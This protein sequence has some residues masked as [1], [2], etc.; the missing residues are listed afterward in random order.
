MPKYYTDEYDSC[1]ID[2]ETLSITPWSCAVLDVGAVL[3]K[4]SEM[5]HKFKDLC[6][7]GFH[8][9]FDVAHQVTDNHRCIDPDT[10]AWWEKQ[11]DGAKQILLPSASD[12]QLIEFTKAFEDWLNSNSIDLYKMRLYARGSSFDI[13]ILRSIYHIVYGDSYD[14]MLPFRYWRERDIRTAIEEIVDD[15]IQKIP[16]PNFELKG[17]IKHNSIHDC[18]KDVM[19]MSYARKIACGYFDINNIDD[20]VLCQK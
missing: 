18:A 15:Q 10:L 13:T 14:K 4:R 6:D 8:M 12:K 5:N 16:V 9:K 3:F 20:C 19:A 1:V 11:T 7:N 17:F 2:F